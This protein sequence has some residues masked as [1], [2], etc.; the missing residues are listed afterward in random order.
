MPLGEFGGEGFPPPMEVHF[1]GVILA[2]CLLSLG[3][4]L[5]I[6]NFIEYGLPNDEAVVGS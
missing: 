1:G 4:G 5:F 2:A 6:W 3:I